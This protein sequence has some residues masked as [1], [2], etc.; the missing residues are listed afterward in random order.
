MTE[1]EKRDYLELLTQYAGNAKGMSI[2]AAFGFGNQLQEKKLDVVVDKRKKSVVGAA[3]LAICLLCGLVITTGY[4]YQKELTA[5]ETIMK[6]LE[7]PAA[8]SHLVMETLINPEHV[9]SLEFVSL[10]QRPTINYPWPY[11]SN[12]DGL[13]YTKFLVFWVIYDILYEE[14]YD[15]Y[16]TTFFNGKQ[17][18]EFILIYTKDGWI[19]HSMGFSIPV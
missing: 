10:E 17:M 11:V 6:Y 2:T 9:A 19:I 4:T 1:A 8:N 16:H 14:G 3:A 5:E 12:A 7:D 15:M 13:G 18:R